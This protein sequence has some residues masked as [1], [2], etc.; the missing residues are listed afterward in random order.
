MMT[1]S[2][3][4]TLAWCPKMAMGCRHC[5]KRVQGA[6]C[7]RWIASSDVRLPKG[8][9]EPSSAAAALRENRRGDVT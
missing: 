6:G 5:A 4:M 9:R 7:E 2:Q 1:G 3:F 8:C